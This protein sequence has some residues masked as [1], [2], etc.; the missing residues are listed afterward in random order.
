MQANEYIIKTC[1]RYA[2][3]GYIYITPK[4]KKY[5]LIYI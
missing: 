5:K 3:I 2:S 4:I 1:L